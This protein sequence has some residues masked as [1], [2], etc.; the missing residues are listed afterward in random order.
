M[1]LRVVH[2]LTVIPQVMDV[3]LMDEQLQEA[4]I[5]KGAE[6]KIAV[7]QGMGVAQIEFRMP[8][9]KITLVAQLVMRPNM[10]AVQMATR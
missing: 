8:K 3:A 10:V 4:I 1:F 7:S 9:E 2:L 6:K 5:M